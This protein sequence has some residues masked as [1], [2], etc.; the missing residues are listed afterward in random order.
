MGHFSHTALVLIV[1]YQADS[2]VFNVPMAHMFDI[3]V[4]ATL[5]LDYFKAGPH[6]LQTT[7]PHFLPHHF[8]ADEINPLGACLFTKVW[9][10]LKVV[11][12]DQL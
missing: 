5:S 11:S 2:Y 1:G 3:G 6:A 4:P 10:C 12:F 8:K 9:T 7:V